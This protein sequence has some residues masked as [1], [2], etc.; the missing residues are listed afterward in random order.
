MEELEILTPK[1]KKI[2]IKLII[3]IELNIF[4]LIL[5]GGGIYLY[6]NKTQIQK[7]L[8]D[9]ENFSYNMDKL[10]TKTNMF[11]NEASPVIQ[12]LAKL[13]CQNF[14]KDCPN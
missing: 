9:I 3:L 8:M 10:V 1:K 5:I 13:I 11:I 6:L 14:P 7:S 12:A 4:F 2:N